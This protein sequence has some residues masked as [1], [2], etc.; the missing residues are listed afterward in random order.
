MVIDA[1]AHIGKVNGKVYT[2]ENLVASMDKAGIDTS[3]LITNKRLS[4]E[5]ASMEEGIEINKK[6]PQIKIIGNVDFAILDEAQ[7]EKIKKYLSTKK[8]VG[9]KFYLGYES[10]YANEPKLHSIYEFCQKNNFPVVY[11]T[12]VLES[13]FAG[14]LKYSH[15]LTIDEVATQF[16]DLKIVIAHFGNPWIMDAAAVVAKNKN[17]YVDL[18]GYF[19]EYVSIS[20][21]EVDLFVKQ[22]TEFKSFVGSFQKC[23]FGTDWPLYDQK[24][25]LDAVNQLPM[26]QEE[27]DLVLSQNAVKIY[28]L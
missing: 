26:T 5:G 7:I 24:E 6:Y 16:P 1:H 27:R 20:K 14:L 28:N 2:V 11:H 12:G 21:E 23:L 9:V 19:T 15:P 25:Y 18:S 22:V 4:N 17:V 13:S 8:I 10:F 3:L